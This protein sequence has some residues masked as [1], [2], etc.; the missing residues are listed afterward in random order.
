MSNSVNLIYLDGKTAQVQYEKKPINSGADGTIYATIDNKLALKIYHDPNKDMQ[1]QDKLWQMLSNAPT[2]E[3]ICWPVAVISDKKNNFIGYAMPLLDLSR[4][5]TIEMLLSKRL[6]ESLKITDS[7]KFRVTVA[8]SLASKVAELH[9]LGHYIIDLKPANLSFDKHTGDVMVLDCDGFSIKGDKKRFKGHQYTSGYIAP[10]AFGGKIPPEKLGV[11]QDLFALTTILFQLLNN[12]LHPFQGVSKNGYSLPSDNQT[13]ITEGLYPYAIKVHA[14]IKPSP[15]SIHTDFPDVLS[16][17][18]TQSLTSRVRT[19]ANIWQKLLLEQ[20]LKLKVCKQNSDHAYWQKA[21]PHC[22]L[23]Q[24]KAQVKKNIKPNIKSAVKRSAPINNSSQS[25]SNVSQ[26]SNNQPGS[27]IGVYAVFFTIAIIVTLVVNFRGGVSPESTYSQPQATPSHRQTKPVENKGVKFEHK[28]VHKA[29]TVNS[30]LGNVTYYKHDMVLLNKSRELVEIP[31]YQLTGFKSSDAFPL[32]KH[33]PFGRIFPSDSPQVSLSKIDFEMAGEKVG[34][35]EYRSDRVYHL[36]DWQYDSN[37]EQGYVYNCKYDPNICTH[38]TQIGMQKKVSFKFNDFKAEK[39][40]PD[41]NTGVSADSYRPWRFNITENGKKI[42]MLSN[43]ELVVYDI[44]NPSKPIIKQR[45]PKEWDEWNVTRLL[46]VNNGQ[47]LFVAL[48]K[49]E[50]YGK[51]YQGFVTELLLVNNTYQ[52]TTNFATLP[53]SN[54]M[55]GVDIATNLKGDVL[56]IG[57]YIQPEQNNTRF[58]I[59]N[60]PVEVTIAH[61]VIKLW[62]KTAQGWQAI[63]LPNDQIVTLKQNELSPDKVVTK[64]PA[65]ISRSVLV[66]NFSSDSKV[67]GDLRF[68]R[69]F[70]LSKS[71]DVLLSGITASKRRDYIKAKASIFKLNFLENEFLL[72]AELDKTYEPINQSN[73]PSNTAYLS[74]LSASLSH[75][76]SQVALGWFVFFDVLSKSSKTRFEKQRYQL[77]LLNVEAMKE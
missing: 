41:E 77:E 31:F 13:K 59:L 54:K 71:G 47:R 14:K 29:K 60:T 32:I 27:G 37:S 73:S 53:D 62:K 39:S 7:Y 18:F 6:R 52:V 34:Q 48:A 19:K 45:L 44:A 33:S 22:Q 23:N 72:A 21:C 43:F 11:G 15:W 10:E 64:V 42:V 9:R 38:V 67:M 65:N 24:K 61:P 76:G 51:N 26:S 57:E 2:A 66:A 36:D 74:Y 1:R 40:F 30:L 35:L 20:S 3:G 17:A 75:D 58:H 68:N 8:I 5:Y 69:Q 63:R 46:S 70:M 28:T 25:S 56:A 4:C 12:G 50:Q 49:S 55:S 16:K